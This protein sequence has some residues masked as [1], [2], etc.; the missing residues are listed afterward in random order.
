MGWGTEITLIDWR[1]LQ[2]YY[3]TY[4]RLEINGHN[5][6]TTTFD[7]EAR[8]DWRN[9]KGDYYHILYAVWRLLHQRNQSLSFYAGNDLMAIPTP[10]TQSESVLAGVRQAEQDI[11]I[12]L[13]SSAAPWG[14]GTLFNQV[15]FNFVFNALASESEGKSWEVVLVTQGSIPRRELQEF[16]QSQNATSSTASSAISLPSPKKTKKAPKISKTTPLKD[17]FAPIVDRVLD[18]WNEEKKAEP[19][20]LRTQDQVRAI[21][22]QVLEKLAEQEPLYED[23]I[24]AEI[25]SKIMAS[26]RGSE[27]TARRIEDSLVHGLME[28]AAQGPK[29]TRVFDAKWLD[30]MAGRPLDPQ[31]RFDLDPAAACAHANSTFL[32]GDWDEHWHVERPALEAAFIAFLDSPHTVFSLAGVSGIGKSWTIARILKNLCQDRLCLLVGGEVLDDFQSLAAIVGSQLRPLVQGDET[33][34]GLLERWRAESASESAKPPLLILDDLTLSQTDHSKRQRQLKALCVQAKDAGVK[35]LFS[36]QWHLWR[37][38]KLGQELNSNDVFPS[39]QTENIVDEDKNAASTAASKEVL[40]SLRD[41]RISFIIQDFTA[42]ELEIAVRRRLGNAPSERV[43]SLAQ[44]LRSPA[45]APLRNPFLL[46]LALKNSAAYQAQPEDDSIF[47]VDALLDKHII[48]IL[49]RIAEPMGLTG[50][51]LRPSL[52]ALV[53]ALWQSREQGL[54]LSEAV[55]ILNENTGLSGAD[56]IKALRKWGLLVP[57]APIRIERNH[58][59]YRLFALE[60]QKQVEAGVELLTILDPKNEADSGAV[61]AFLRHLSAQHSPILVSVSSPSANLNFMAPAASKLALAQISANFLSLNAAVDLAEK[62]ARQ[63][64]RWSRAICEGLSQTSPDDVQ[65]VAFLAAFIRSSER[66]SI[67]HEACRALAQLAAKGGQARRWVGEMYHFG[68]SSERLSGSMVLR[69]LLE[70]DPVRVRR[71]V[72]LRLERAARFDWRNNNERKYR[73]HWLRWALD[74][75]QYPRHQKAAQAGQQILE[76]YRPLEDHYCA[77]KKGAFCHATGRRK[78]LFDEWDWTYTEDIAEVRGGQIAWNADEKARLFEELRNGDDVTRFLAAKALRSAAFDHIG[79]VVEILLERLRVETDGGV[80][81]R[82]LWASYKLGQPPYATD[83]LSAINEGTI[84]Q[85]ADGRFVGPALTMLAFAATHQPEA[86]LNIAPKELMTLESLERDYYHEALVYLWW[87]IASQSDKLPPARCQEAWEQ[88][89]KFAQLDP[90]IAALLTSLPQAK[91]GESKSGEAEEQVRVLEEDGWP[92]RARGVVLAQMALL[93]RRRFVAFDFQMHEIGRDLPQYLC[94]TDEIA[95]QHGEFLVAHP[96]FKELEEALLACVAAQV[97][98]PKLQGNHFDHITKALVGAAFHASRESLDCLALLGRFFTDPVALVQQVPRTVLGDWQRLHLITDLLE[99]GRREADLVEAAEM[100]CEELKGA[101]TMDGQH[102]QKRCL[103]TLAKIN[104]DS[105]IEES[106]SEAL[107]RHRS[108]T[109]SSGIFG[110]TDHTEGFVSLTD[111]NPGQLLKLLDESLKKEDDLLT[112]YKWE[113]QTQSWPSLLLARVFRRMFDPTPLSA[114]AARRSCLHILAALGALPDSFLRQQWYA[115]Y[116]V[117][118][119]VLDRRDCEVGTLR[120]DKSV[121]QWSHFHA[122][123]MLSQTVEEVARDEKWFESRLDPSWVLQNPKTFSI[124]PDGDISYTMNFIDNSRTQFCFPAIRLAAVAISHSFAGGDPIAVRMAARLRLAEF[125]SDSDDFFQQLRGWKI[126]DERKQQVVGAFEQL[127]AEQKSGD[128]PRD[129]RFRVTHLDVLLMA[130]QLQEAKIAAQTY[131]AEAE[132]FP[133]TPKIHSG[134]WYDLACAQARLGEKED[135]RISLEKA[136]ELSP[137]D[138][139]NLQHDTDLDAVRGE[140]WFTEL[141]ERFPV[142]QSRTVHLNFPQGA[143]VTTSKV[144]GNRFEISFQLE[145]GQI[146]RRK[147]DTNGQQ[148]DPAST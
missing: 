124:N 79:H 117:I 57:T 63:D 142:Q 84:G 125:L 121:L 140:G 107:Q 29:H 32:H 46:S 137:S 85:W 42:D 55:R 104:G 119:N 11:W 22:L 59:A 24:K 10:Q 33:D 135:C 21:A 37:L 31:G 96:Q 25:H 76:I 87:A 30:E 28:S 106:A 102:E 138:G 147:S 7:N 26:V 123:W 73:K 82:L 148:N 134:L 91:T 9:F 36:G 95:A 94:D 58:I 113:S 105:V 93:G 56:L 51:D 72:A 18:A 86:V 2:T 112:L 5:T 127:L 118:L 133:T 23:V 97:F 12:Q 145:E 41:D 27:T 83:F 45:F 101:Y 89:E 39:S 114:K 128:I 92:F 60:L 61:A 50:E 52:D 78:M 19:S 81:A 80:L 116:K 110:T 3:E 90:K 66:G 130:G 144:E 65:V 139:A 17:Q 108:Q 146:V 136:A 48:H 132:N 69:E 75:V 98:A 68:S 4:V 1:K 16:I 43:N 14:C 70:F 111:A 131:L 34:A 100:L 20:L 35:L 74:P 129:D 99:H 103:A 62:L 13:K 6:M 115:V 54:V 122:V 77:T 49:E 53:S 67:R 143:R 141:M 126:T 44:R 8:G 64:G 47:D 40:R 109:H 71:W 15:L 38:A 88:L 120:G